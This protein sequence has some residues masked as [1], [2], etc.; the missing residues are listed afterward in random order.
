MR[1]MFK[2]PLFL[3]VVSLSKCVG[4]I[5]TLTQVHLFHD[6][7]KHNTAKHGCTRKIVCSSSKGC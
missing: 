5:F 3:L 4:M 6:R 2:N 7:T 1:A